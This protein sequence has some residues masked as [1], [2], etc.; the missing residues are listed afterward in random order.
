MAQALFD[1]LH[2]HRGLPVRSMTIFNYLLE[3]ALFGGVLILL[4]LCV[5]RVFRRNLGNRAIYA[6]WL[7]VAVRLLLPLALPNSLMNELR[8]T[9]SVDTAARPV[10]DQIRVRFADALSDLSWR[11]SDESRSGAGNDTSVSPVAQTLSTLSVVNSY[12]WMG[13]WYLIGYLCAAGGVALYMIG[14]NAA[15]R[16]KLRTGK[17]SELPEPLMA[18]YLAL[19]E[20]RKVKPLPVYLVDPLASACLVGVIRP[21]IALPLTMP[22]EQT[23]LALL[24]ELCHRKA[25]DEWWGLLRNVCCVVQWFNPLVWIGAKACREDGEL[26][27]DDRVVGGMDEGER[28][29]YANVLL[30]CASRRATPGV[31]VL[32]TSMTMTGRHLKQR[33]SS[34]LQ[35]RTVRRSAKAV[36]AVFCGVVLVFAFATAESRPA[37]TDLKLEKAIYGLLLDDPYP[38]G[39]TWADTEVARAP[40]TTAEEAASQAAAYLACDAFGGASVGRQD[41]KYSAAKADEGWYVAVTGWGDEAYCMLLD[42]DG[43]LLR[44]TSMVYEDDMPDNNE[45]RR[46]SN[47]EQAMASYANR[48][49]TGALGASSVRDCEITDDR[50][51]LTERFI[52]AGVTVDGKVCGFTLGTSYPVLR[53]WSR[54][55]G[56][57][58]VAGAQ[59]KALRGMQTYLRDQFGVTRDVL[60]DFGRIDAA[61]DESARAWRVTAY[62]SADGMPED[63]ATALSQAYGAHRVYLLSGV[64][65]AD[66]DGV[67]D[68]AFREGEGETPEAVSGELTRDTVAFFASNYAWLYAEETVPAGTAYTVK[69]TLTREENRFREEWA[70]GIAWLEISYDSPSFSGEITRWIPSPEDTADRPGDVVDVS[71]PVTEDVRVALESGADVTFHAAWHHAGGLITPENPATSREDAI[72][73]AANAL[74]EQYGVTGSVLAEGHLLIGY[75]AAAPEDTIGSY[76]QFYFQDGNYAASIPDDGGAPFSLSSPAEGN[77]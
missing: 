37:G 71:Q 38:E 72:R 16:R 4:M 19:C 10:A 65:P 62:L 35:N 3:A 14:R 51:S 22:P 9:M 70:Q 41:L 8:P 11:V 28:R 55:D 20:Q 12:G 49:A 15:F 44:F 30:T 48:F 7:L 39:D 59:E 26:A 57:A 36:F 25:H 60:K 46:P 53:A 6:A 52:S 68:V 21:F 34:I 29:A 47:M 17:V 23:R 76:W 61:W 45:G 58:A 1:F 69:R 24:H 77:G 33:L 54:Q 27:C 50:Y 5:R 73:R 42:G 40:V 67:R 63:A 43:T 18:E 2:D 56:A 66:G 31:T 32:A 75:Y 64:C 13:K 74:M